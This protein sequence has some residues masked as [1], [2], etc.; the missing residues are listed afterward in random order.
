MVE[1]PPE[2]APTPKLKEEQ[3]RDYLQQLYLIMD[4]K[5]PFLS[6]NCSQETVAIQT[7]IPKHH[8][9]YV[10]NSTL[11][12]SFPDFINEYR[13]QYART[14][15]E[16]EESLRLTIDALGKLCGFSN[17]VSFNYAFKKVYSISP[18]DYQHDQKQ[19]PN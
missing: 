18:S 11:K 6:R 10:V 5:R 14:L 16:S 13:C 9:S 12:K 17:R 19:K 8:L 4:T 1:I 7:S 3:I 15:L 2:I